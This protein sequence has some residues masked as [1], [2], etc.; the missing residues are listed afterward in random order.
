VVVDLLGGRERRLLADAGWAWLERTGHLTV[1]QLG[2][3]HNIDPVLSAELVSPDLWER[4]RV[5]AVALALL[6]A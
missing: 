2:I 3:D 5:L 6:R 4:P 1:P